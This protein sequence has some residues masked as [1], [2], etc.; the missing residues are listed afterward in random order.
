MGT[1]CHCSCQQPG[2]VISPEI[3]NKVDAIINSYKDKPGALM[4]VL[5][6]VQEVVV[7]YPRR[8]RSGSP[9]VS[10]SPAATSLG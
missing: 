2:A 3:F 1:Q 8:Y 5:Q 7:I 6:E 4:P 9:P 10:T